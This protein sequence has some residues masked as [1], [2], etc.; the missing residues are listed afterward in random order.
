VLGG[1]TVDIHRTPLL[2]YAGPYLL[3][4]IGGPSS[5]ITDSDAWTTATPTGPESAG[6]TRTRG[7]LHE[8]AEGRAAGRLLLEQFLD[9]RSLHL[10]GVTADVAGGAWDISQA[11]PQ[12]THWRRA[13]D[14]SGGL[15]AAVPVRQCAQFAGWIVGDFAGLLAGWEAGRPAAGEA[16]AWPGYD[17]TDRSTF[18]NVPVRV[19]VD[20]G[21]VAARIRFGYAENGPADQFFCTSRQEAC[22]T[23]GDPFA[24]ES[25]GP[26]W[27]SC[28]TRCLIE[29]PARSGRVL[30]YAVDRRR[31][32]LGQTGDFA[33]ANGAL[34][35]ARANGPS[36]F[37]AARKFAK[38][39][40]SGER[41]KTDRP[42]GRTGCW[43]QRLDKRRTN[44]GTGPQPL[45]AG[46]PPGALG[47]L[48][49]HA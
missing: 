23:G 36:S 1:G 13:D 45:L 27:T 5:S 32:G 24:W 29:V 16:S 42:H 11:D 28:R 48:V 12:G 49:V 35:G 15:G 7:R 41:G 9:S 25:E 31:M 46:E 19:R 43:R 6:P 10:H 8:R 34:M 4:D 22:S 44:T 18:V 38:L 14:G 26:A 21:F 40:R 20:D 2:G 17:G 37:P 3:R 47:D 30:Y 39:S 33:G